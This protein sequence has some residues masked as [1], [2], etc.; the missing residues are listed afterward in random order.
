MQGELRQLARS[1]GLEGSVRF[2]RLYLSI[3]CHK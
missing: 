3:K 2:I 1:L